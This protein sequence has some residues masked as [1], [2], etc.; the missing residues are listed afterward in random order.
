MFG[1]SSIDDYEIYIR[2]S[3]RPIL[4]NSKPSH[5]TYQKT[6]FTDFEWE[7]YREIFLREIVITRNNSPKTLT[8]HSSLFL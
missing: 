8:L 5:W 3:K 6:K 7:V 2:R 1:N 4:V